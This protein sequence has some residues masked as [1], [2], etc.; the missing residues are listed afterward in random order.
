MTFLSCGDLWLMRPCVCLEPNLL[1]WWILCTQWCGDCL[2]DHGER[3][4]R[5]GEGE[6][7]HACEELILSSLSA[8][9]VQ[10][11]LIFIWHV[12]GGK[13]QESHFLASGWSETWRCEILTF[14][15]L[16]VQYLLPT[17]LQ[18]GWLPQN[19]LY[20]FLS[21]SNL[22]QQS[23][24]N[25]CSVIICVFLDN[26]ED[27]VGAPLSS[28]RIC[29]CSTHS[30]EWRII[31]MWQCSQSH[32]LKS[33]S[34]PILLLCQLVTQVWLQEFILYIDATQ[35]IEFN[36]DQPHQAKIE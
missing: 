31:I 9:N 8:R 26:L 13:A 16:H 23:S 3:K 20:S 35:G 25:S 32:C 12:L 7:H 27:L 1:H 24:G 30:R 5:R 6:A 21:K 11:M 17:E 22:G 28:W 19:F 18:I 2:R 36:K 14:S 29:R 33:L 10:V 34:Q 15:C 4:R